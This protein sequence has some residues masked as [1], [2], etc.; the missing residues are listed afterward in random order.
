ME[1][2]TIMLISLLAIALAGCGNDKG[3]AASA[4]EKA[5]DA[6]TTDNGAGCEFVA[7]QAGAQSF[8]IKVTDKDT[9][10]AKEFLKTCINPYTKMYAENP[11]LAKEGKKKFGY[12]S[13]TQCHGPNGGGQVGPSIIDDRWQYSKHVT[14]KGM[15]ETIA[16]GSDMGMQAWHQQTSGNPEL[17]PTDDILKIIGWL[18]TQYQGGDDK[19][20]L[21]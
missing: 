9:P 12:W 19:P 16:H 13:C 3:D 11:D 5:A 10:E 8:T 18:R 14:D 21:N 17:L 2:V 1:K 15:F 6:V 4:P 20:W 7:T